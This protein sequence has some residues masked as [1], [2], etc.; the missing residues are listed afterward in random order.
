MFIMNRNSEKR[1]GAELRRKFQSQAAIKR[2]GIELESKHWTMKET[3]RGLDSEKYQY[4][5]YNHK[6]ALS[7]NNT[8]RF[9]K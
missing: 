4:N 7:L 1:S 8:K 9:A 2:S 6:N 5:L 3:Q